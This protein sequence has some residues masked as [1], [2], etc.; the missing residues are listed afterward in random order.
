M[1]L[2][3]ANVNEV[4]GDSFGQPKGKKKQQRPI[5][6]TSCNLYKRRD[7]RPDP[8]DDIMNTYMD[9]DMQYDRPAREVKNK[10]LRNVQ[11]Q[12]L[13]GNS[14]QQRSQP[15][16]KQNIHA[17]CYDEEKVQGVTDSMFESAY[18]Y[19][20]YYQDNV[21]VDETQYQQVADEACEAAAAAD[22]SAY[23]APVKPLSKEEIYRDIILEK[24]TDLLNN[25]QTRMQQPAANG[26]QGYV[27]LALYMVSGVLLIVMMEQILQL[28]VYLR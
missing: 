14:G 8:L 6:P 17:Q 5:E 28:G 4:W 3:Y 1:A 25:A 10:N 26:Q 15:P 9:D 19:E 23:T 20:Q 18:E 11:Q 27:E 7:G 2:P 16:V 22:P 24:Y 12:Q 21:I 13:D